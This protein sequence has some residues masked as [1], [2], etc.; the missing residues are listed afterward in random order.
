MIIK[1][2]TFIVHAPPRL[3]LLEFLIILIHQARELIIEIEGRLCP[4][5]NSATLFH[6]WTCVVSNYE[7]TRKSERLFFSRTLSPDKVLIAL[8]FTNRILFY[9]LAGNAVIRFY[10][11]Y[12]LNNL[13]RVLYFFTNAYAVLD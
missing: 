9:N 13:I 6:A 3:I 10:Y 4:V 12:V 8:F 5:S 1:L 2:I 11:I 7:A